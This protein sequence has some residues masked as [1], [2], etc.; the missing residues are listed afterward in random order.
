MIDVSQ[1]ADLS[2]IDA[3]AATIANR[4][5]ASQFAARFR[6]VTTQGRLACMRASDWLANLPD[7]VLAEGTEGPE[8]LAI[9]IESAVMRQ[10]AA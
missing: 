1:S 7:S 2:A 8:R 4:L 9:A 6:S 3:Y 10:L 5:Q